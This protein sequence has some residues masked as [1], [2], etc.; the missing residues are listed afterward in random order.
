VIGE[1]NRR[2]NLLAADLIKLFEVF[3]N[4]RNAGQFVEI[5]QSHVVSL[6]KSGVCAK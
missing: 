5:F 6:N 2:S 4:D 1:K 3:L